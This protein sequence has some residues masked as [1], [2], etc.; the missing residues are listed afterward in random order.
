MAPAGRRTAGAARAGSSTMRPYLRPARRR[1][2]R[3]HHHRL[4]VHRR[5]RRHPGRSGSNLAEAVRTASGKAFVIPDGTLLPIDLI[6]ADR[7]FYS[8]KHKKHG[9][10]VQVFADPA[11]RLLWASPAL[12]GSVHDPGPRQGTDDAVG[13][14]G[15]QSPGFRDRGHRPLP[16]RYGFP[17]ALVFVLFFIDHGT[18]RVH[19]AGITRHPTG[20]WVIQQARNYHAAAGA[21]DERHRRTLDRGMPPGRPP[22]GASLSRKDTKHPPKSRSHCTRSNSPPS[23]ETPSELPVRADTPYG[24]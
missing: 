22:T 1:I 6:A 11:G 4:P 7:P 15:F 18:R 17:S 21:P 9:M 23:A 5:G 16:H 8:G 20:P 2:R 10:N 14:R 24:K 13:S 19:I 3:G 12:P